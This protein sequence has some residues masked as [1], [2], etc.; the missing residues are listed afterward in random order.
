MKSLGLIVLA[1]ITSIAFAQ[2]ANPYAR[3]ERNEIK[4]LAPDE[5]A[6]LLAGR[7]MGFARAAELN[8]YPG[9]MHVIELSDQLNLTPAQLEASRRLMS[10]HRE[11]ARQLGAELVD[12]ERRL[13]ALFAQKNAEASNVSAAAE[14]SGIQQAKLRAEHLNTHLQQTALLTPEQ[15]RRYSELRGYAAHALP[16]RSHSK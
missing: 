8:G 15:I 11:R 3:M 9:P 5:V 2:H 1:S 13:D 7:G 12:A 10:E 6:S 16:H 4:S 14:R